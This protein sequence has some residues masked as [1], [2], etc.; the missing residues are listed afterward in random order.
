MSST[1]IL[2]TFLALPSLSGQHGPGSRLYELLKQVARREVENSFYEQ[3]P[4]V[5]E[6]KPFGELVLPYHK[7]GAFDDLLRV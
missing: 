7:M 4:K 2:E 3:E 5:R 1:S 6:F